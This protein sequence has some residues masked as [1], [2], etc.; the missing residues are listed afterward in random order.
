MGS[1][2]KLFPAPPPTQPHLLSRPLI[3]RTLHD[4]PVKQIEMPN[5]LNTLPLQHPLT[6]P[7]LPQTGSI[8]IGAD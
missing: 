8:A 1:R 3:V 5:P 6:Q 4:H 2:F 7:P